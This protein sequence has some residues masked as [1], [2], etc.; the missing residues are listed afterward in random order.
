VRILSVDTT[1]ERGSVAI[2]D[3]GELLGELRLLL[4]SGATHSERLMPGVDFLL[5]A[6][7]CPLASLDGYAVAT[8]PGSFTG[9]RIG[10]STVQGL[11]L[12][13]PRPCLG[14]STLD[15]LAARARGESAVTAA[16]LDAWR[17]EV[18]AAL[19]DAAGTLQQGPFAEPA[20][21]FAR[22][23]PPGAAYIGSG[24][25]RY[26]ETLVSHDPSAV[27]PERSLFLAGTLGRLAGPRLAA[28]LG[29]GPEA[30]RPL[31]VR[32]AGASVKAA[33]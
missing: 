7:G 19:Y 24:A 16:V 5:Q 20:A 33:R 27:F 29:H 17:D 21:D 28:G 32:G 9:L 12:G 26:R 30:L 11:A 23:A 15:V 3:A 31:Y 14:V 25:L 1:T 4:P 8:G 13:H 18:Y 2:T 6:L 10:I 22:R